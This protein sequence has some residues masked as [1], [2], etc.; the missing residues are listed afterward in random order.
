VYKRKKVFCIIGARGGSKGLP[1]KNKLLVDGKP[2]ISYSIE[3]SKKIKYIDEVFV[4]T[5]DA[6]LKEI[7]KKYGAKIINRPK[8][9]AT[10]NANI[11]D[12]FKHVIKN[13]TDIKKENVIIVLFWTA[14]IIRKIK[15]IEKCIE[16]YD[17]K[18]DCIVSVSES[19]IRPSW[20]FIE[21]NKYLEFWQKTIPEPNRQQQKE[22][23][24]YIN[25]SVVVTTSRFL[26]KQKKNFVG[27]KMKGYVMNDKHSMDIDTPF[28][29]KI[30][31]LV[32][33]Q[34]KNF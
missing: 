32:V 7:S 17:D 28:D 10:D 8:T 20:L 2:V 34:K 31:K 33:E 24:F 26:M 3:S 15:D 1:N 6:K 22:R 25:G 5:E 9:L 21:K 14:P 4:S 11:L 23:Y 12:S 30:T 18:I 16:M 13:I 27:G 19:K 29:F